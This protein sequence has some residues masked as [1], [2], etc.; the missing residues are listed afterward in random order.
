MYRVLLSRNGKAYAKECD[1]DDF[2]ETIDDFV[3]SGDIILFYENLDNLQDALG[4]K[5]EIEEVYGE[6]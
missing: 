5:Y 4:D 2:V 6:E 3:N 1:S